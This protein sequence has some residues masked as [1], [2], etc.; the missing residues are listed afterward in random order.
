MA[1]EDEA[2]LAEEGAPEMS[3]LMSAWDQTPGAWAIMGANSFRGSNTILHG[4]SRRSLGHRLAGRNPGTIGSMAPR[5]WMRLGSYD[6]VGGWDERDASSKKYTPFAQLGK[7]SNW[8]AN[9]AM[10]SAHKS[11]VNLAQ[12][13]AD[14]GT[15]DAAKLAK[16]PWA[17]MQNLGITEDMAQSGDKAS[18]INGGFYSRLSASSRIGGEAKAGRKGASVGRMLKRTDSTLHDALGM[19]AKD[20]KAMSRTS[21]SQ[22]IGASQEGTLSRGAAGYMAGLRGEGME[23]GV[24]SAL[25]TAGRGSYLKGFGSAAE[26]LALGKNAAGEAAGML[27]GGIANAA[28]SGVEHGAAKF[29]AASTLKTV[30]KAIPYVNVAM[31]AW[32]AYDFVKAGAAALKQVPGFVG[33]AAKSFKGDMARPMFGSGFKDNTVAATSRQ[34]G[35]TAIQNSRLNARSVLGSEAAPLHAH[36]G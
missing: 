34:R 20:Y 11:H 5:H 28:A 36:F 16:T 31:W 19:G 18:L 33:D 3:P 17:R 4:P 6:A 7:A 35:V 23:S 10:R 30:G 12:K 32:T 8:G 21:A 29:I 27:S 13:M 9:K 14:A 24:R 26:H 22:L 2:Q 25:E 15:P 1:Y